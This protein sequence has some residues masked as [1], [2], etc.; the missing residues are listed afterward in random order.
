MPATRTILD[1]A[2]PFEAT[3]EPF[4]KVPEL[5]CEFKLDEP[6]RHGAIVPNFTFLRDPVPP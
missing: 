4:G 3:G 5:H 1:L 6:G 2:V